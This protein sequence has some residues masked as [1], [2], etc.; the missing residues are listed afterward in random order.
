MR[1]LPR[2]LENP[3]DNVIIYLCG[4]M[5]DFFHKL[6]MTPND[7][8]TLSLITGILS[9]VF[10]YK[11]LPIISVCFYFF[12]Y[13]FD[14]ADG[15][16]A[17]KYKMVSSGG[18]LYDHIKDWTVNITYAI[19]LYKRN[20]DTLT[21]PQWI[22]VLCITIFLIV[23]QSFYFAAQERYYDKLDDIPSMAWLGA[24]VK[25]KKD[26]INVLKVTRYFGCGT[27]IMYVICL[28]V[29]LE[30]KK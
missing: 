10:L 30:Y 7:I 11:G 13:V 15:Y 6:D 17:R 26:A 25:T 4:P 1:K 19:V 16:H 28:T 3:L 5:T 27:F 9:I 18:D 20:K 24:L 23:M 21:R 8:T 2:E 12:S 14:C 29:C 22:V